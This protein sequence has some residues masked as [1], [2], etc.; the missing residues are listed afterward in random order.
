MLAGE[1]CERV[2]LFDI[3][4]SF[5]RES[6]ATLRRRYPT[7]DVDGVVGR[8]NLD[9]HRFGPG[10]RRMIA[11][12]G[13]TIGNFHPDETVGFLRRLAAITGPTDSLL[14]GFDL[15][16]DVDRLEAAYND[17]AGI[18]AEFNLNI[19]RGFNR[20][21]G[22]DYDPDNFEHH[23]FYDVDNA[24]IEMRLR[25]V[26]ASTVR[27]PGL[28]LERH[29]A[30]GDEVRTEISCKYTRDRVDAYAADAGLAVQGWFTDPDSLF[31]L[32]LL[33]RARQ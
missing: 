26:R 1:G 12:F 3:N 5:L 13:S 23:A 17:A 20:A 27:L 21:T 15:V 25:A 24:W 14:I 8:F 18:T 4:E 22:A 33:R 29:F 9:L 2:T 32:A 31:A 7:V 16:K 30:V 6:V 10:G 19:L 28:A 11:F